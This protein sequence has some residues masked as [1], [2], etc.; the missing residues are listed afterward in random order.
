L[1]LIVR[2]LQ[3]RVVDVV[4]VAQQDGDHRCTMRH[5]GPRHHFG[6]VLRHR[7]IRLVTSVVH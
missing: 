6:P 1:V 3:E 7:E 5:V 4:V 2:G